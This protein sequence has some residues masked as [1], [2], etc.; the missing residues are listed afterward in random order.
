MIGSLRVAYNRGFDSLWRRLGRPSIF[1]FPWQTPT[2]ST[3]SDDLDVWL[4]DTTGLVVTQTNSELTSTE[5]PALF[6]DEADEFILAMGGVVTEGQLNAI[7]KVAAASNIEPRPFMVV[8]GSLASGER[9]KVT[10]VTEVPRGGA[11]RFYVLSLT[12][13]EA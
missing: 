2:G 6:G 7:V 10:K 13:Y 1:T 9:Y 8:T 12:R 3:Y 4:S 11:T 5:I